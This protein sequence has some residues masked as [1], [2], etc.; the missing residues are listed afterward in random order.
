MT[1]P[2]LTPDEIAKVEALNKRT[3][4]LKAKGEYEATRLYID[5]PEQPIMAVLKSMATTKQYP[6]DSFY[7]ADLTAQALD[8]LD[9]SDDAEGV[10][11]NLAKHIDRLNA[12][13]D[14]VK[15][16][17]LGVTIR[18][19]LPD[20]AVKDLADQYVKATSI[21]TTDDKAT[22]IQGYEITDIQGLRKAIQKAKPLTLES[23]SYNLGIKK[24]P[25]FYAA[26]DTLAKDL[27][28]DGRKD[29]N[30]AYV[31]LAVLDQIRRQPDTPLEA[32]NQLDLF[33]NMAM[34][35][36]TAEIS[37]RHQ[38]FN[39]MY[40]GY[41]D[42]GEAGLYEAVAKASKQGTTLTIPYKTT[43]MAGQVYRVT[44]DTRANMGGH[45]IPV[46]ENQGDATRYLARLIK[47]QGIVYL[48]AMNSRSMTLYNV[49][50]TDLLRLAGY[51]GRIKD[52]DYIDVTKGMAGLYATRIDKTGNEYTD[53]KTGRRI[54]LGKHELYGETIHPIGS[55]S[56]VWHTGYAKD[57]KGKRIQ[58][59]TDPKGKPIYKTEPKYIKKIVRLTIADGMI[60][61]TSR[62]ATLLSKKL[63]QLDTL[64]ERQYIQVGSL[65]SETFSQYQDKTVQGE[66][67][68]LRLKTLLEWRGL[69]DGDSLRRVTQTKQRL[70]QALDKLTSI[71]HI[72]RWTVDGARYEALGLSKGDL[73]RLILIYPTKAIQQAL[74]G[75]IGGDDTELRKLLKGLVKDQ[76]VTDVAKQYAASPEVIA[77][78]VNDKDTVD[79]LPLTAYND[80]KALSYDKKSLKSSTK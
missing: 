80:L 52:T 46:I 79:S 3:A 75:G 45:T 41:M 9:L 43:T 10:R 6:I 24:L 74:K 63:L 72:A 59:G 53:P 27:K 29:N 31:I 19:G 26:V 20:K 40:R 15:D 58:T 51:T 11:A 21:R 23:P 4:D 13:Y 36:D 14:Q 57:A 2:N 1:L 71:G 68:R 50:M 49:K 64:N 28:I 44:L 12:I 62:R 66:P 76:G 42:L 22:S 69:A 70:A 65:I 34:G 56:V 48:W 33:S 47:A 16:D 77:N 30:L 39:P 73:E 37:G 7:R 61:P 54:K 60:N 25:D 18:I 78:I 5:S 38:F 8:A 17:S 67:I 32:T 55:L 35:V